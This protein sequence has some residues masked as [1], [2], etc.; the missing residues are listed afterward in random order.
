MVPYLVASR[1]D[2]KDALLAVHWVENWAVV[3]AVHWVVS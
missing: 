2:L 1:V 3:K